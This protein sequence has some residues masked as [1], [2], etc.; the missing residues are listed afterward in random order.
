MWQRPAGGDREREIRRV[1]LL[2]GIT[3]CFIARSSVTDAQEPTTKAGAELFARN[4]A[5]CHEHGAAGAP[6]KTLLGQMPPAAI[7][8]ALTR[9]AMVVQ[10]QRLS[11][12]ER[13]RVVTYLAGEA[14]LIPSHPPL[15]C[16]SPLW[17]HQTIPATTTAWGANPSSTRS[18]GDA[19]LSRRDVERLGLKWSIVFPNSLK[20]RSQPVVVGGALFIG[21]QDGTVFALDA[22]SGCLFWTFEAVAEIRGSITYGAEADHSAGR[23][24]FGD[25]FANVYSL[26]AQT[27]TL[28]WKVKIDDQ[29]AA[30]VVGSPLLTADRLFVPVGSWGEEIAAAAPDFICC[31]FRGSMV[32]INRQSGAI[33]WK[34]YT[35]PQPASRHE[36]PGVDKA[37]YGPSGASVWSSPTYDESHDLLYFDTGDNFSDP[38]DDNSDAVFALKGADG[39]IVWKKQVTLGD[40][41]NDGCLGGTRLAN[42]PE[43]FGPDIDFS[44]PPILVRERGRS[45]LVAAQ[46]SGDVYGFEPATGDLLWHVRL[47]ADPNPWGGGIWF[48]MVEQSQ[49]LIVPVVTLTPVSSPAAVT[50]TAEK[51]FLPDVVNGVWAIDPFSGRKLWQS[52]VERGCTEGVC[53]SSMTA[54]LGVP[55]LVFTA[56]VDGVARAYDERTGAV[57]WRYDTAK[58]FTSI[59][60]D[61]GKGGLLTGAGAFAIGNRHLYVV[62]ANVLL[63]FSPEGSE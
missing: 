47:S 9:G 41:Y 58:T 62:N 54:P 19:G 63:A 28:Q 33:L 53:Q 37:I 8:A 22:S 29:A 38:G 3:F 50:D 5:G 11:D 18:V 35:I 36:R 49:R 55:G 31:T 46:K 59:N 27:G 26:D 24:Y 12:D 51:H 6:S 17:A 52:A 32:A 34:R 20:V 21:T 43:H 48:G 10:G 61:Q 44:A 1:L 60:G 56:T 7:F 25:V 16:K 42:C 2:L 30:R 14:P 4:C 13:R 45:I 39:S 23:L 15:M 40:V 57:I